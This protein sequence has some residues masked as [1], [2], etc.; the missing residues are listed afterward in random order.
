MGKSDHSTEFARPARGR[1]KRGRKP[2]LLGLGLLSLFLF[3]LFLPS[4]AVQPRWLVPL[5]NRYAGLA[6][7][8]LTISETR[9]G[10]LAPVEV[11]GLEVRTAEGRVLAKV[12][13]A[14]TSKGLLSWLLDSNDLGL[15]RLHG[16]EAAVEVDDGTTNLEEALA[17]L[18]RPASTR[19]GRGPPPATPTQ[20]FRGSI[21]IKEAKFVVTQG[22][23]NEQWVVSVPSANFE[24]PT[25]HQQ[26]GAVELQASVA[27]ASGLLPRATGTI[28]ANIHQGESGAFELRA[29]LQSLPLAFWHVVKARLPNIPIEELAGGVSATLAGSIVNADQWSIDISGL[30]VDALHIVAPQIVGE[31]AARLAQ[32]SATGRA[33]LDRHLLSIERMQLNCDVGDIRAAGQLAWPLVPPTAQEPFLAG[34]DWDIQGRIDLPKFAVAAR[35]LL[36]VREDVRLVAGQAHFG[37]EQ[38]LAAANGG[39]ASKAKLHLGGIQAEAGG[40]ELRWDEPL[41]VELGATRQADGV[42][43]TAH[44]SAEFCQVE[45]GGTLEAGQLAGRLDL[46]RLQQRLSQFIELPVTTMTGSANLDLNW[47]SRTS[48]TVHARGTLRTTPVRIASASGDELEEP[49]WQGTFGAQMKHANG[50]PTELTKATLDMASSEEQLVVQLQEPLSLSTAGEDQ[51]ARPSAFTLNLVGDLSKWKRRGFFW[52]AEPP[53]MSLAGTASLAL[54]GRMDLGHVEV[55]QANWRAQPLRV[56]SPQFNLAETQMVGNFRGLIDTTDLSRLVV[57]KLEIQSTSF[58]IGARDA[59]DPDGSR[60]RVGQAMF[61]VDLDRLLKNMNVATHDAP[62]SLPARTQSSTAQASFA[63][64]GQV[65]GQLSWRVGAGEA[66]LSIRADGKEIKF[67]SP[68]AVGQLKQVWDEPQIVSKAEAKWNANEGRVDF[69]SI[70]VETP[71]IA[72]FG[73][74]SYATVDSQSVVRSQGQA[75]YDCSKLSRKLTPFT[76]SEILLEGMQTAPI[77]VTWT[78]SANPLATAM[79][80]LDVDARLGWERAQVVGIEIGKAEVPVTIS[81]G[82]LATAASFPVSGGTFRWDIASDLTADELVIEQKPMTVLENVAITHQMCQ[83]WLKYVTPLLAEATS[84]DGRLSLRLDQAKLIPTAANKQTIRGQLIVHNAAVGPGPLSN[85]VLTLV[86]QL[87]AV[88]KRE[89][90][91]QPVSAQKIWL[92]MPEQRIDFEMQDGRVAHRNVNFRIGDAQIL[93]GGSVSVDG[94]VDMTASMPVPDDWIQKSPWLEGMRGQSLQFPVHGTLAQPQIDMQMLQQFSRQAVQGAASGLLQQGLSRGI[95]KLFG[96]QTA[97]TGGSP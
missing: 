38:H 30:E 16:V 77:E 61:L 46:D 97:P 96:G 41:T 85:Q 45:G 42:K 6:P 8:Q 12:G 70:H 13:R 92:Q 7:I 27:E 88:R 1:G 72:Y 17:H 9:A 32:L 93:T 5:A 15:I 24:L 10:W 64:A 4:L 94:D 48:D 76:S 82:Q 62:R 58:S 80:G 21:E 83:G 47:E 71:W 91:A 81:K 68:D 26:L 11:R 84:V 37:F 29:R 51:E 23:R 49:A 55:L 31:Q 89:L 67:L 54:S 52:L 69:Q 34:G 44:S 86:K 19:S 59:A 75:V 57:E 14:E 63:A 18:L 90:V 36:P 50:L 22:G 56:Q 2:V 3:V 20:E 39:P 66:T 79:A 73:D 40:Q 25:S 28:A 35:S 65:H 78:S 60:R 53:E 43:F 33:T 87:D 95:E 74:V